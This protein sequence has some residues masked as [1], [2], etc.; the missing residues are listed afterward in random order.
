[1]IKQNYNPRMFNNAIRIFH[2]TRIIPALSNMESEHED[3]EAKISIT[4]DKTHVRFYIYSNYPVKFS[5]VPL[6]NP[7]DFIPNNLKHQLAPIFN[8]QSCKWYVSTIYLS[9]K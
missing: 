1:M 8:Q 4:Y 7:M 9:I 3:F 6:E 2:N 5:P